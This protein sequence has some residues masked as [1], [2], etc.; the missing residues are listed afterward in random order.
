M[1]FT[2]SVEVATNLAHELLSEVAPS[3]ATSL[4]IENDKQ[5]VGSAA[6]LYYGTYIDNL[7]IFS[8]NFRLALNVH[9]EFDRAIVKSGLVLSESDGPRSRRKLLGL[10]ANGEGDYPGL[11]PPPGLP[12]EMYSISLK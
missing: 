8:T 1:G 4:N 6:E 2:H 5:L 7:F 9:R 12:D 10:D 3:G 11:R